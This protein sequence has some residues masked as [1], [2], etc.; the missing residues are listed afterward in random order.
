MFGEFTTDDA[1]ICGSLFLKSEVKSVYKEGRSSLKSYLR[2]SIDNDIATLYNLRID[3][4]DPR[5][6][7]LRFTFFFITPEPQVIS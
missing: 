2:Q 5:M 4:G 7:T 6:V 1:G 3:N